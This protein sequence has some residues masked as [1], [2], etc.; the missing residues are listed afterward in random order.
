MALINPLARARGYGSAKDGVH[1]WYVQRASAL[2]LAGLS[3]WFLYAITR[4]AGA[5]Y[6]AA[7]AFMSNPFHASCAILTLI[8]ML[9]HGMVSI[10]IVI[11]DYIHAEA[12]AIAL[13]L[14]IRALSYLGMVL[15][16]VY[17]LRLVVAGG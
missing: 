11:E 8:S 3:L 2:L 10:Q 12:L 9:Y 14:V 5:D 16:S 4:L 15:G 13:Q 17:L 7:V 6:Q 1:H